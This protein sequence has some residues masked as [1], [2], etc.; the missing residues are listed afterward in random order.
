MEGEADGEV[1]VAAAGVACCSASMS[2]TGAGCGPHGL[3]L[4]H[5][6]AALTMSVVDLSYF[7]GFDV[8]SLVCF[9]GGHRPASL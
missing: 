1:M 4:R 9:A 7:L 6:D 8:A 2:F 5:P 3:L